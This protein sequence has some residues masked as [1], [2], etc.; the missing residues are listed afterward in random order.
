MNH[1]V[2]QRSAKSLLETISQG[3]Q[4]SGVLVVLFAPEFQSGRHADGQRDRLGAWSQALLLMTAE[5]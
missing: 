5:H 3:R 4:A 2:R 1:D